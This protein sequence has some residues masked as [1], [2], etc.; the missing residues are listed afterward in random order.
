MDIELILKSISAAATSPLALTAYLA[1]VLAWFLIASKVKRNKQLLD[2]LEKLPEKDRLKAFTLEIQG[3]KLSS[4]ITPDQWLKSRIHQYLFASFITV[5]LVFVVVFS[6]LLFDINDIYKPTVDDKIKV[7]QLGQSLEYVKDEIANHISYKNGEGNTDTFS[8]IFYIN[9]KM[10]TIRLLEYLGF[11]QKGE[12]SMLRTKSISQWEGTNEAWEL[13]FR[14]EGFLEKK[15]KELF[16]IFKISF[17][18]EKIHASIQE[19]PEKDIL[20]WHNELI[21]YVNRL[22]KIDRSFRSISTNVLDDKDND[23]R[24]VEFLDYLTS[25]VEGSNGNKLLTESETL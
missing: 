6:M 23:V 4:G 18:S 15:S 16:Y 17:I 24:Y 22:K 12:L 8:D 3:V 14:V 11:D 1:A 5:C 19:Q 13:I 20:T 21:D 10:N 7:L 9:E 2:S 25:I